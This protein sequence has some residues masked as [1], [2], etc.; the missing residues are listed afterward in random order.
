M[1]DGERERE[2]EREQEV[3]LNIS[4][5]EILSSLSQWVC[6]GLSQLAGMFDIP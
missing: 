4:L 3:T 1:R 6:V 5:S 2:G